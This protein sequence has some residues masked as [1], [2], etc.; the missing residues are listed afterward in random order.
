[1]SNVPKSKRKPTTFEASHN[2]IKL[3]DEVTKLCMNDFGFSIDKATERRNRYYEQHSNQ[4]NID[5]TM[6]NYDKKLQSFEDF[7]IDDECKCV[8]QILRDIVHEFTLGNSI[9]P[10]KN[11]LGII[12]YV[13]RRKH[14]TKAIGLCFSLRH[15]L[16]YILRTLP[17]DR[18]KYKNISELIDSEIALI[19]GVRKSDNRFL[20]NIKD[21][22]N[23]QDIT[24]CLILDVVTE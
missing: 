10:A 22:L 9:Y 18:N 13:R 14:M 16:N 20:R 6:K 5:N 11:A 12:E 4:P 8:L 3:R 19:K 21:T 24:N 1:M 17:T 7:F 23:L 15:E 2:L